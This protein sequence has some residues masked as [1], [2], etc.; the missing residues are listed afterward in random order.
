MR[1]KTTKSL[2]DYWNDVRGH[3]TAPSRHEIHPSRIP[4][5]LADTFMLE[6]RG[7]EAYHFRLAGTR[8]CDAFGRELRGTNFLY[9]W[10]HEDRRD[11][12]QQLDIV[13]GQCAAEVLQIEAGPDCHS[14]VPFEVILLPL[15]HTSET[16]DRILGS[17]SVLEPAEWLYRTPINYKTL[18]D[19]E[20]LWPGWVQV[21]NARTG[22]GGGGP[23]RRFRVLQGGLSRAERENG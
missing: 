18:T 16:V 20:L 8:I 12:I 4:D 19:S 2:F 7:P 14:T 15:F 23:T 22:H 10:D 21:Q 5:I 11:L 17:I 1:H 3:R 9:G 6:R 13:T